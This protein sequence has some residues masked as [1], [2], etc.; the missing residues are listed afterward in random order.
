[1]RLMSMPNV[2][3]ECIQLP[4]ID[5]S[6]DLDCHLD[7]Q[8]DGAIAPFAVRADRDQVFVLAGEL[9]RAHRVGNQR[10]LAGG[11]VARPM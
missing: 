7:R 11:A 10:I 8:I 6:L 5:W 2:V 9:D 3:D 4:P 1:M